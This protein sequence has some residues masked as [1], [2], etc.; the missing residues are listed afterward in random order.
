MEPIDEE[1]RELVH[2]AAGPAEI[3]EQSRFLQALDGALAR[4]TLRDRTIL[5]LHYQ[6]GRSYEEIAEVLELPMG[7]VKTHLYRA[8]ERLKAQM[9]DWISQCKITH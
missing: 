5:A 9:G 7:T 1:A 2:P 4:L 8:R 6:E 3:L